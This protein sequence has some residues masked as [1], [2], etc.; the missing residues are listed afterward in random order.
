MIIFLKIKFASSTVIVDDC[1][2]VDTHPALNNTFREHIHMTKWTVHIN[3][4]VILNEIGF[5]LTSALT[6]KECRQKISSS[7][8]HM[9]GARVI[10][11]ASFTS[12]G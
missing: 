6:A 5:N 10:S 11:H 4:E 2:I 3:Q 7:L 12:G 8:P 1:F 9:R